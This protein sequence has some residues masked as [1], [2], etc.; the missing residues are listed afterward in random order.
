MNNEDRIRSIIESNQYQEL[1]KRKNAIEHDVE[2]RSNYYEGLKD[3]ML[4]AIRAFRNCDFTGYC[5]CPY[6]SKVG[7][8]E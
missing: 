7:D 2:M 3:G 8:E 6:C 5:N 4:L 1:A